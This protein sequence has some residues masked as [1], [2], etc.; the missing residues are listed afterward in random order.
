MNKIILISGKAEYG[1]T[2]FANILRD[3]A[4]KKKLKVVRTSF[5]SDLK[6]VAKEYFGWNGEKDEA[7]RH[8]LQHL[9]TEEIRGLFPNHWIDGVAEVLMATKPRWDFAII[10]DWRFKK[11]FESMDRYCATFGVDL[12]PIRIER[13]YS[14][15]QLWNNSLTLKAASHSSELDLDNFNKFKYNITNLDIAGLER[16]A[17]EILNKEKEVLDDTI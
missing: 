16:D 4:E 6:R 14:N 17:K 2:T 10:D 7:G 3:E 12:I 5:A 9:G 15:G 8:L 13:I 11:E 1:K